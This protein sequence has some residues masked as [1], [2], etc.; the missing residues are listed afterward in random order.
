M[1]PLEKEGKK[2]GKRVWK[3]YVFQISDATFKYF[4]RVDKVLIMIITTQSLK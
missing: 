1:D 3:Q 2:M 4:S